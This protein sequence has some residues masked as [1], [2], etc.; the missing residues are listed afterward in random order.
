MLM[1]AVTKQLTISCRCDHTE[2]WCHWPI[3]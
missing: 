2:K 3:Y 1:C